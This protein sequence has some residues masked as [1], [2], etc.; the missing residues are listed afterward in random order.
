VSDDDLT[1]EE[2]EVRR[3]LADARHTEPLPADVADRLD[4]VLADLRDEPA[5]ST[6]APA[7]TDLAAARRRRRTVRNLLVA[8]AAVTVVGFGST[9]VD[10]LTGSGGDA[11][12][13][14]SADG[15]QSMA[16][17][18]PRDEAGGGDTADS[19]RAL[20]VLDPDGFDDQVRVLLTHPN[21]LMSESELH[22]DDAPD[23]FAAVCPETGWGDG[24]RI[25]V[26]YDDR[27]AVLVVRPASGGSRVVDLYLCG[28]A[29]PTRS[30]EVPT[31]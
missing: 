9:V 21:A 31:G 2:A 3:L 24:D 6:P 17:S 27:D 10:D 18:E 30:V 5:V 1:P 28:D 13:G 15:S 22:Y 7:P 23:T 14:S 16:E 4:R 29:T 26:R 12:S 20:I 8:A 25:A 19:A 11:D